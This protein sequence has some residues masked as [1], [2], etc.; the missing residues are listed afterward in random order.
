MS[1]PFFSTMK[2]N[3]SISVIITAETF[4]ICNNVRKVLT[5]KLSMQNKYLPSI[6]KVYLALRNLLKVPL[7]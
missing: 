2:N 7:V 5:L 3:L 1:D 6:C 4:S